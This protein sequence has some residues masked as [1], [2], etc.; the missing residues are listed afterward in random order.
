MTTTTL[1]AISAAPLVIYHGRCP[2]G[3]GAALA[4]WLVF[5]DKADYV[6]GFYGDPPPDVQGRNVF[7]LDFSYGRDV[8][9]RIDQEA[10]SLV[11]LDHH[12]TA[13]DNLMG[14]TCTCGKVH[15]DMS[16][17]GA[18]LAWDYFHPDTEVP[19]LI[20]HVED[21]DL[22]KW[23]YPDSAA[24]LAALDAEK[25]DFHRWK[26]LLNMD[27]VA[28][29]QFVRRGE[30]MNVKFSLLCEG[31][32]ADALPLSI[33]G[34]E[35]LMVAASADFASQ[36]G[37]L[38]SQKS[39]TFAAVWRLEPK[40]M[41]KISLRSKAPFDVECIARHF[42]G[43]GHAQAASMRVPAAKLTEMI[44]GMLKLPG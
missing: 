19:A 7:I 30:A 35:G 44:A 22:W 28:R 8:L 9:S 41:M 16:H 15:I 3:F 26:E 37:S 18:R 11:L 27:G 36:V 1:S 5:G 42:G 43:G 34:V 25:H 33:G 20:A 17:S 10:A 14:F 21:R 13:Q 2:D 4:A 12:K 29:E 32:A 31:I 23:Q 6:Q 39:G 40:G 24:F 38:L